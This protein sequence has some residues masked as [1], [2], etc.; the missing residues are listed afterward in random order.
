[1]VQWRLTLTLLLKSKF[2]PMISLWL[3]TTVISHDNPKK[4]PIK[5]AGQ[6]TSL[7]SHLTYKVFKI[8]SMFTSTQTGF[9]Q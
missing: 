6:T 9:T 1:M 3:I 5:P 8:N 7:V 4:N 2:G